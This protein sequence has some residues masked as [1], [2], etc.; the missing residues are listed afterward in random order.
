MRQP[1]GGVSFRDFLE[2]FYEQMPDATAF[3]F[4]IDDS[5]QGREKAVAGVDNLQVQ[6]E[7]RIE[8]AADVGRFIFPQKAVVNQNAVQ[9]VADCPVKQ[10]GQ[11]RRIDAAGKGQQN[12]VLSDLLADAGK[13]L[14]ND[15]GDRPFSVQ[16][17]DLS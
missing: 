3:F 17:A 14:F 1:V 11:H 4:G 7:L 8:Q 12:P 13:V 16:A 2:N 5:P 6:A 10:G 9:L 15:R